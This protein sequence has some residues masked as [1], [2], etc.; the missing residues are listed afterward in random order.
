MDFS[1]IIN[2]L[3]KLEGIRLNSI[4]PGAE[5]TIKQ[6][7]LDQKKVV[8]ESSSGKLHSRPFSEFQRIW[9]ALLAAPAIRVEEV[10]NGSGSSRN[11][12]E[13]I[14]ANLPYIQ[15]LKIDNKKHIAYVGAP[16]HPYG[17]I[18]QMDGFQAVQLTNKIAQ[19]AI[20]T[21]LIV[22]VVTDDI[23]SSAKTISSL[24]G[25]PGK[26]ESL[27]YYIYPLKDQMIIL[28]DTT[29]LNIPCGTYVEVTQALSIPPKSQVSFLKHTWAVFW[30][31]QFNCIVR[32]TCH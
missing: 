4:R 18:Q 6:V 31:N 27:G 32:T 16:M 20:S 28:A 22:L 13:T 24:T 9:E 17:T 21:G 26:A 29:K 30:G 14:F 8:V 5:I 7:D 12:P 2:D 25:N 10:L 11:Q 3:V 23:V 1:D 19:A 15:W